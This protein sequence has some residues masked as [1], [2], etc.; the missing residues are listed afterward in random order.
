M[1]TLNRNDFPL[2]RRTERVLQF[3]EGNFLRCFV[4][5]QLDIL[6]EKTGLDAGVVVVRP[7]DADFPPPLDTQDGLYTSLIRGYDEEGNLKEESRLISCVNREISVYRQYGE[8]LKLAENPDLRFIFSN[9]TEAGIAFVEGDRFEDAPPSSYPAKLTRF[10]YE[11]FRIFRGDLSRGFIII[12][13]ELIDYNGREL[14]RIVGEY[15]RLWKL[16][17]PFVTWLEEANTFCSS[18]VD[19]IV[20]GYPKNEAS[21]LEEKWGYRDGFITTGEYFHLFAIQGPPHVA[22]ELNLAEGGLNIRIVEDLKPY[23]VRKVGILNGC[24][25][26]LVPLAYLSGV[27]L[28]KDAVEDPLLNRYTDRLI[29]E[30]I[31]PNLGLPLDY[32]REFASRVLDRFKNPF[33]RHE[34]LSISLNSMTKFRTRLLPQMLAHYESSGKVPPLI[35]L[36]LA[37]LICF[38]RGE[39]NGKTYPVQDNP[40]FLEMYR[41]LW[42]TDLTA[43]E[44]ALSLVREVLGLKEHWGADL[45]ALEGLTERTAGL[46]YRIRK[47][48]MRRVLEQEV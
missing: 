27:E 20:T 37:A 42:K 26:A 44:K 32:A 28:V 36:A 2:P 14:R 29:N 5:W 15:C 38:Y 10:L 39:V 47:D 19:R 23:K 22:R 11:R 33:I 21:A 35:S 7:I 8:F 34:F 16:E 18:L 41:R 9:T 48:G 40:E 17:E 6:N 4:D 1:K 30:E 31:I 24:H 43:P 13:C 12:P 25:T 46:V 3:G 45:S